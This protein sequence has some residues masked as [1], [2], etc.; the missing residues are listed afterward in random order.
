MRLWSVNGGLQKKGFPQCAGTINGC[1]I[2]IEAP[3]N[4]LADYHNRKGWHSIILQGLVENTGCFTDINVG[5]PGRVHDSRVLQNSELY[6]KAES[7]NLFPEQTVMMG[8]V[9]VSIV[10]IGQ[11]LTH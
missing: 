9:R 4:C 6:A 8:G 1:H 3:Q 5:W 7:G 2:P 10:I 11:G